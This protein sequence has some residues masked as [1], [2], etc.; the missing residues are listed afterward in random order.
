MDKPRT[1]PYAVISADDAGKT[2]NVRK[3][4]GLLFTREEPRAFAKWICE[5]LNEAFDFGAENVG[6]RG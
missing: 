1:W 3:P 2:A 6:G 4:N 5:C